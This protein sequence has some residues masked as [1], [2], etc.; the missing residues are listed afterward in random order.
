MCVRL[1]NLRVLP[2]WAAAASP[3]RNNA[4]GG[5]QTQPYIFPASARPNSPAVAAP[6]TNNANICNSPVSDALVSIRI[7]N[8]SGLNSYPGFFLTVDGFFPVGNY[9][10]AADEDDTFISPLVP[11]LHTLYLNPL[12]PGGISPFYLTITQGLDVLASAVYVLTD[13]YPP[14]PIPFTVA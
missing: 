4:N 3:R 1:P 7:Q 14:A 10:G 9:L 13:T 6:R 12:P 2:P 11:G 8:I 5:W